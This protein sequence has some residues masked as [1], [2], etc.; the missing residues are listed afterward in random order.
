M[1]AFSIRLAGRTASF[2]RVEVFHN[3]TWGTICADHWDVKAGI[4]ACRM[5]GYPYVWFSGVIGA[6][7]PGSGQIWLDD[8]KC[9]GNESSLLNCSHN[10]WGVHDCNHYEDV[11]VRCGNTATPPP[12]TTPKPTTPTP[13]SKLW[14]S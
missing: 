7:L 2:G 13:P 5:L 14:L 3:G 6:S 4:V 1:A 8:V 10:A 9:Q 12:L 11:G